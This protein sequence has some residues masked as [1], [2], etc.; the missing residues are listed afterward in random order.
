MIELIPKTDWNNDK[1]ISVF[2]TLVQDQA[3]N[4]LRKNLPCKRGIFPQNLARSKHYLFYVNV[5]NQ[6]R[7]KNWLGDKR[8]V[9]IK[10][11]KMKTLSEIE[12]SNL[13]V[14]TSFKEEVEKSKKAM[15]PVL[16]EMR[17]FI[18]NAEYVYRV[19]GEEYPDFHGVNIEFT[20]NDI[21]F[22][23]EKLYNE[24][25]YKIVA[26]MDHLKNINRYHIQNIAKQFKKPCNF[27]VFTAKKINAWINYYTPIYNQAVKEDSERFQ[28]ITEFLKSIDN[29]TVSWTNSNLTQGE[30]TRN[31][32]FSI[33]DGCIWTN[34][35]LSYHGQN[36]YTKF[37]LMADNKFFPKTDY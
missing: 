33:D 4:G 27:G 10:L 37:H 20:L 32:S 7:G 14:S 35:E 36:N 22:R 17:K 1:G 28:N 25:K 15:L 5:P 11:E 26:V 3:V 8:C 9:T 30:I 19:L 2:L 18:P 24:N 6:S 34:I 23:L 12:L 21:R 13:N 31:F 29:E 16:Q